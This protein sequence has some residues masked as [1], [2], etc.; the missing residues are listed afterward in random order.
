MLR[1]PR[2]PGLFL[3]GAALVLAAH[4][5]A[6]D[7]APAKKEAADLRDAAARQVELK[8]QFGLFKE[9]LILLA[10]RL[11]GSA[12][13]EDRERAK[14]LRKVLQAI[15]D[16]EVDGKFDSMI[17]ALGTEGGPD[18]DLLTKALQDNKEL[19]DALERMIALVV[20]DTIIAVNGK[21]VRDLA[22]LAAVAGGP[23]IILI[24]RNSNYF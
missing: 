13:A 7:Q 23:A 12:K 10:G 6:T 20:D 5:A 3:A 22:E 8:R 4:A 17:R 21:P 15:R 2:V 1:A 19:R 9:K 24:R 18:A 16:K 14:A 11:E